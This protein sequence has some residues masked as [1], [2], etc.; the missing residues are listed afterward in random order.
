MFFDVVHIDACLENLEAVIPLKLEFSSMKD[1]DVAIEDPKSVQDEIPLSA[2]RLSSQNLH[3][4]FAVDSMFHPCSLPALFFSFVSFVSPN[5]CKNEFFLSIFCLQLFP[6]IGHFLFVVRKLTVVFL[7]YFLMKSRSLWK[8]PPVKFAIQIDKP[9]ESSSKPKD[10]IETSPLEHPLESMV[11]SS[12][13]RFHQYLDWLFLQI[14]GST[15]FSC[16]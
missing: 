7:V 13:L 16:Q 14:I 3:A 8:H 1:L 5:G 4:I 10:R 11:V 6:H 2:L 12:P 15:Y 9:S